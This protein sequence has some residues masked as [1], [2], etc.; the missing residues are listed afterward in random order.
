MRKPTPHRPVRAR[1]PMG[2][3]AGIGQN[4]RGGVM[5]ARLVVS[6]RTAMGSAVP[7]Y[8]RCTS[9]GNAGMCC[10]RKKRIVTRSRASV[11]AWTRRI[12]LSFQPPAQGAA[13]K[14]RGFSPSRVSQDVWGGCAS[15]RAGARRWSAASERDAAPL[16]GGRRARDWRGKLRRRRHARCRAG[17]AARPARATAA[18]RGVGPAGRT[19]HGG[20]GTR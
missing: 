11:V 6:E 14:L 7:I 1:C 2:G 20:D 10:L 3:D 18:T 19:G 4:P 15:G 17:R 16:L 9:P 13:Q 5:S 12:W 8:C